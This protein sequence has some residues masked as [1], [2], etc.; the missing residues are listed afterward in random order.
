M[1]P[2]ALVSAC[3]SQVTVVKPVPELDL[4]RYAGKWYEIASVTGHFQKG[5]NCTTADYTITAG[6][7]Y[8]TVENRCF[9]NGKWSGIKGKAFRGEHAHDGALKVQFFWPFRA[10]YWVIALAPDYSWAV[11]S[12]PGLKYLWILSRTPAMTD[13]LYQSIIQRLNTIGFDPARLQHTLQ[14]C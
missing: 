2:L 8:V 6:E 9:R 7:N 11:V 10:D 1:L 5:C 12:G 14:N 13:E 3:H 4:T